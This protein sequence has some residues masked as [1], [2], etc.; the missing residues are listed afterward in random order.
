MGIFKTVL[1]RKEVSETIGFL[2]AQYL[3]F[4]E[5]TNRFQTVPAHPFAAL[6]LD[7]P[8]IIAAWHGQQFLIHVV[9]RPG[10]RVSA[11]ASRS[12]DGELNASVLKHLGVRAIR[13]SGAQ[14]RDPRSKGGAQA[15]RQM[16]RALQDGENVVLTADVPKVSRVCGAGLVVLAKLSGRPVV[17][18][19][20]VTS[21]RID[22]ESWDRASLSLPFGR[23]AIVFGDPIH[24]SPESD[25][26]ELDARRCEVEAS[27]N[28]VQER[29]FGLVGSRD[30]AAPA[31]VARAPSGAVARP[32]FPSRS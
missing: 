24:V 2:G 17:P 28:D 30:P 27:L 7:T 18:L 16:L 4:V 11:L 6:G 26:G 10:D 8:V 12:R 32:S 1:G 25:A 19:A 5:A 9:R 20:V 13:G 29:A 21:R 31:V 14:G 23:G 3:R 15:L 22:F